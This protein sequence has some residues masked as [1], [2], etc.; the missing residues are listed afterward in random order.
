MQH[1]NYWS[2]I[3]N[4]SNSKVTKPILPKLYSFV[5]LM[6]I[7]KLQ[8][9]V[10]MCPVTFELELFEFF[11]NSLSVTLSYGW[12]FHYLAIT[13]GEYHFDI[14]LIIMTLL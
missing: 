11:S 4:S 9:L 6:R 5:V 12:G 1:S 7:T 13:D 2:K 14:P 3:S 10:G 8:S